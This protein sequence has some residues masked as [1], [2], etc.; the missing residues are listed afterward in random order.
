VTRAR[1]PSSRSTPSSTLLMGSRAG[2]GRDE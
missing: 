2:L 1:G